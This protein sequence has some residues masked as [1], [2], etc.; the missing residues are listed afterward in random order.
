TAGPKKKARRGKEKM[1]GGA[2]QRA[3]VLSNN[4]SFYNQGNAFP[5]NLWNRS[6]NPRRNWSVIPQDRNSCG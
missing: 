5:I 4:S 6:R 3:L 1:D 2:T